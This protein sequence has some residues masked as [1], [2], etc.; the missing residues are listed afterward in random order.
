MGQGF[1]QDFVHSVPMNGEIELKLA[2]EGILYGT[3]ENERGQPLEGVTVKVENWMVNNGTK[4]LAIVGTGMTDD[5]GKFRIAELKPGDYYVNFEPNAQRGVR[6]VGGLRRRGNEQGY[7]TQFYPG[8]ADMS[9]ATMVKLRA[10]AQLQIAQSLKPEMLYQVSGVVRGANLDKGFIV[11]LM[12]GTGNAGQREVRMDPKTGGFQ[13]AGVPEGKYLLMAGAA[14]EA[15]KDRPAL[16]ASVTIQ[17]NQDL[18]GLVLMLTRG[19]SIGVT[20]QDE[21]SE[22]PEEEHHV[23]VTLS[24]TGLLEMSQGLT[25]PP[26]SNGGAKF[27]AAPDRFEEVQPGTYEVEAS[28]NGRGYVASLQCGDVDLLRDEL[29][30]GAGASMPPVVVR[31]RDDGA[32]IT[33]DV[34]DGGK[35]AKA[36]V[37]F[38]SEEYPKSSVLALAAN[39]RAVADDLRPG[40]YRV[41][42]L[43]QIREVEF[44]E[45]EFAEKYLA[46]GKEVNV[47]AGEQVKVEVEAV[48]EP[49]E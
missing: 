8:V 35:P 31:L 48:E 49:D 1:G 30:V 47:K 38:Y 14:D 21:T 40:A 10:G 36:M 42:A 16:M 34:T 11:N 7:G 15:D 39:G 20:L 17:V 19:T 37:V 46:T 28:A 3:V 25:V 22:Q 4:E 26:P 43:R 41:V 32:R 13:I 23:S 6:I 27:P 24:S 44:R 2:P 12:N 5:E 33:A 29:T 9:A 18:T 45:V